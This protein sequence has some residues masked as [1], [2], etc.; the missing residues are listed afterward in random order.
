[1]SSLFST[2]DTRKV[3]FLS[4]VS[5]TTDPSQTSSIGLR[6]TTGYAAPE[7]G[8]G[9]EVSTYGDVYSYGIVLLEM[10]TGKR[11][12]HSI[13]DGGC[14][15]VAFTQGHPSPNSGSLTNCVKVHDSHGS[16]KGDEAWK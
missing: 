6:G 11:P 14:E 5:T 10:V 3:P 16:L 12:T 8:I 15:R 13:F 2:E 4:G 1:M 7:Y 9:N